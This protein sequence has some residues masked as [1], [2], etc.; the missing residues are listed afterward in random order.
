VVLRILLIV[1]EQSV[2]GL[3]FMH[4]RRL[5]CLGFHAPQYA[6]FIDAPAAGAAASTC[7]L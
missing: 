1:I 4:A 5:G 2:I 3:D 7:D 6:G